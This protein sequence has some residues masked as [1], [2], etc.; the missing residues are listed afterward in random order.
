MRGPG[1]SDMRRLLREIIAI[2]ALA[3]FFADAGPAQGRE[4]QING[5]GATF[6]E[7]FYFKAFDA[8][9]RQRGTKVNYRGEG[10]GAGMRQLFARTVDFA[11]TDIMPNEAGQDKA[12]GNNA[13]VR[14]QPC[15]GSE[16]GAV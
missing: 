14:G 9:Y 6:P 2:I 8:Y 5:A 10:S 11:G 13:L 3:V 12:S 4:V 1:G 7:P 15:S 16:E